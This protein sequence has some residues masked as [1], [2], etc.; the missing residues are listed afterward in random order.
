MPDL[1]PSPP[2]S[3]GAAPSSGRKRRSEPED[4]WLARDK[5]KHLT[6]S[7]LWTLSTQYVLVRKTDWTDS[8]ALPASIGSAAAIGLTKEFY[9]AS[10]LTGHFC[11]RDLVADAVGIAFAAG[12]IKL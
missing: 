1:A 2:H 8:D 5:A 9:D 6:V 4:R 3:H 11:G 10:T 7:A 12:L